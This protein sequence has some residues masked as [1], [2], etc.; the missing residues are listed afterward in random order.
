MN[1]IAAPVTNDPLALQQRAY[2]YIAANLPGWE[3]QP[4]SLD[5]LIIEAFSQVAAEQADIAASVLDSVFRYFGGLVGIAPIDFV[6]S[7]ATATITAIDA[8]GYTIPAGSVIGLRDLNGTLQGFDLDADLVIAP[9]ATT[10]VMTVTAET[11]GALSNGLSGTASLVTVPSSVV[12]ATMTLTGGGADAEQD[13]AYLNRLVETL[14]TMSPRPVLAPDFA[15]IARMVPGVFRATAVDG[16]KPGPPYTGTGEATGQEKCVTVAVTDVN[17]NPAGATVRANVAALLQS[18]REQ[19]FLVYVVDPN[20]TQIDS[21]QAIVAWPSADLVDVQ[22]RVN[23]ALALLLSPS[24]WG[25]DNA[26][27][28]SGFS[29][30]WLNDPTVRLSELHSAIMNVQGVRF[31]SSLTFAR[32]V[33]ALGT[34][35]ATLGAGSAVPALPLPGVFTTTVTYT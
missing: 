13:A 11:P 4:G 7:T 24:S 31:V 20:Y 35:N 29:G 15:V 8:V 17:G 12:A 14:G 34:A 3:P 23:A 18:E 32:H 33:D 30:R 6:P 25:H 16:L 28:D 21:T 2:D 5:N 19:N 26:N 9:G 22:T 10:G 27:G 1:Y